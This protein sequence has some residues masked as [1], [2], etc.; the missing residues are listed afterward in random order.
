MRF[1]IVSG[2]TREPLDPV[3]YLSNY[4]TGTMGSRL[5]EA[6]KKRRHRVEHIEC[7]AAAE[8]ARELLTLLKRRVPKNDV[9]IMA[10]A[11]CDARPAKVSD[12][13]IKK[14]KLSSIRLVKNPDILAE[15][16]KI[17]DPGQIFIGFAL[18]SEDAFKNA[19]KKLISKNLE[20]IVLQRVMKKNK[21]FGEKRIDA[22]ILDRC[23][24]VSPFKM[25]SKAKLAGVLVDAAES[26]ACARAEALKAKI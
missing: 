8:T 22:F 13:K 7:P 14:N 21:P 5:A 26:M 6:A 15:L 25:V 23:G 24:C 3:R 10:A 11:V 9:L 19:S 1:L 12:R 18:E 20:L 4:S 16:S 2:P 17:K